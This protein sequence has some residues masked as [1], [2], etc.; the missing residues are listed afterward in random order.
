VDNLSLAEWAL[1]AE[2][3]AGIGLIASLVFLAFQIRQNTKTIA[4]NTFQ[5][6]SSTS[7]DITMRMAENPQLSALWRKART[8]SDSLDPEELM[9]M[10]LMLRSVFRNFENYYYQFERGYLEA[11]VW[12]GYRQT[13][14]DQVSSGF[15]ATWWENHQVAF[16]RRFVNF[17]NTELHNHQGSTSPWRAT[18]IA[19]I[20][21]DA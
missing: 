20:D 8:S 15:G 7:S 1:V 19:S 5:S 12:A 4:A 10:Q 17:I 3:I 13:M 18:E 21:S 11:D 9:Q 6:I 16:G 2:I 14:L